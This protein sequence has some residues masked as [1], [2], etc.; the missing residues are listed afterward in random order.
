[1]K[2]F[3]I[4]RENMKEKGVAS[5]DMFKQNFYYGNKSYIRLRIFPEKYPPIMHYDHIY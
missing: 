4:T 2:V 1:M 3:D 5:A